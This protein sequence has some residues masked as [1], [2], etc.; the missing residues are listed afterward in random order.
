MT[1]VTPALPENAS[2]CS[3]GR[4]AELDKIED[5]LALSEDDDEST[6]PTCHGTGDGAYEGESCWNCRG[7]GYL[8]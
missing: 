2:Q 4:Q 5:D 8:F 1:P 3:D 6:C 7:R